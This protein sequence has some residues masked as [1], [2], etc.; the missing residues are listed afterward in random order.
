MYAR[1]DGLGS[2]PVSIDEYYFARSVEQIL[3]TGSVRF[4]SGGYYTRG[5]LPQALT[6]ASWSLFG[7]DGFGFRLAILVFS[8]GS[9]VAAFFYSRIWVG[10]TLAAA[11]AGALLL[12]SWHV[13]MGRFLRMYAPFQL[14]TLVFLIAVHKAY[15]EGRWG[16]RYVPHAALGVA[17]LCHELAVFLSPLLFLPFVL[18]SHRQ[19]LARRGA[20]V[21]FACAGLVT[22]AA[23]ILW[24]W[25]F[26]YHLGVD[27]QYPEGYV[28]FFSTSVRLP[29]E[30][31]WSFGRGDATDVVVVVGL[32]VAVVLGYGAK[33]AL[34]TTEGRRRCLLSL[35][36]VSAL[37]H[38]FA[39]AALLG[40]ILLGRYG[41]AWIGQAS[42]G[43]LRLLAGAL[44]AILAW[45]LAAAVWHPWSHDLGTWTAVR[46]LFFGFPD[47]VPAIS[48]WW[49]YLPVLSWILALALVVVL[50]KRRR[51]SPAELLL[52][53][54]VLVVFIGLCLAIVQPRIPS[55]RYSF[56]LYPLLLIVL[57]TAASDLT[58][59][60][61]TSGPGHVHLSTIAV[62]LFSLLFLISEDF[63]VHHLRDVAGAEATFC[64]GEL[65]RFRSP[66]G[67]WFCRDDVAS[68]ASWLNARVGEASGEPIIVASQPTA[69]YYLERDHAHYL[70]R[71][72]TLFDAHSREGGSLDLWSGRPLVST[73][74]QALAYLGTAETAWLL[75]AVRERRAFPE[76]YLFPDRLKSSERLF[77]SI[78]GRIEV[79]RLSLEQ[80]PAS[81]PPPAAAHR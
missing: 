14:A 63:E 48:I 41:V 17:A 47:L 75:R 43:T 26:W 51:S 13:E 40:V 8:L 59:R 72:S 46:R 27:G 55:L 19:D 32:M 69:S 58:A 60:W 25:G 70:R 57:A 33:G 36:L 37:L 39:L 29:A 35:L 44:L 34:D 45:S 62:L 10:P 42:R 4:P 16:L 79:L 31:I 5:L 49:R 30:P 28:P 12:S 80:G 52:H 9:V 23:V 11:V 54:A 73:P 1:T 77:T 64:L 24:N 21:A 61:K 2:R 53:P 18:D 68:A 22:T 71:H 38:Q 65:H 20:A 7:S 67:P 74:G 66:Q 81:P 78:D 50:V 15:A 56:F 3:E 76:Q 6:A